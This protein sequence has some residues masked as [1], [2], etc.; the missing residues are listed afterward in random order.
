MIQSEREA[1]DNPRSERI[2]TRNAAATASS[3]LYRRLGGVGVGLDMAASIAAIMALFTESLLSR[4]SVAGTIREFD[5]T[6]LA[7]STERATH[8]LSYTFSQAHH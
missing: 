6:T 2:P 3:G 8:D 5:S 1:Q 7:D 4:V